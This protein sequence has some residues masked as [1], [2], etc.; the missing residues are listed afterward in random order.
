MTHQG[1][2]WYDTVPFLLGVPRAAV[3]GAE[4]VATIASAAASLTALRCQLS[5]PVGTGNLQIL[6]CVP[7][8]F[9][10]RA[11]S[12]PGAPKIGLPDPKGVGL[13]PENSKS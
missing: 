2:R 6:D 5:R 1:A 9:A 3:A 12:G 8:A 10:G 4:G 13:R 11:F 7:R